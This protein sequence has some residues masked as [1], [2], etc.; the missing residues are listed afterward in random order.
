VLLVL[1]LLVALH[2]A[3]AH[4]LKCKPA[5]D[6][7]STTTPVTGYRLNDTLQNDINIVR[8]G[9]FCVLWHL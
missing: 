8:K 7:G 6:Y 9:G 3:D 1:V 4:L 2:L 5:V